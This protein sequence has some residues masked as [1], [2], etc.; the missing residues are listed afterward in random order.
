[1]SV[2]AITPEVRHRVVERDGLVC[3]YCGARITQ[4]PVLDHQIPD[5]RGGASDETNLVVSCGGCN[6]YKRGRNVEEYRAHVSGKSAGRAVKFYGEGERD[7]SV[8]LM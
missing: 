7:I 8:L 3:W 1:M 6:A 2:S 4:G 5:R